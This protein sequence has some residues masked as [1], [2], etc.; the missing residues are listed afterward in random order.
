MSS[1]KCHSVS[2]LV[3]I[4]ISGFLFV[5]A[6]TKGNWMKEE[7]HI[8]LKSYINVIKPMLSKMTEG[9]P[10]AN[11]IAT[12]MDPMK[13]FKQFDKQIKHLGIKDFDKMLN[14]AVYSQTWYFG[15]RKMCF[16]A[17]VKGFE[18]PIKAFIPS[19]NLCLN[20]DIFT[21]PE[22]Y[23]LPKSQVFEALEKKIGI[24]SFHGSFFCMV[25][26]L[27]VMLMAFILTLSKSTSMYVKWKNVLIGSTMACCS[28]AVITA[29]AALL[30]IHSNFKLHDEF[31]KAKQVMHMY[32]VNPMSTNIINMMVMKESVGCAFY[33]AAVGVAMLIATVF[34]NLAE[35]CSSSN[36]E[37]VDYKKMKMEERI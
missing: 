35:I 19:V 22:K 36:E 12:T 10:V 30:N 6:F 1:N 13:A 32:N 28:I 21:N 8:N 5:R 37:K 4:L 2:G 24:D 16:S 17:T 20:N 7:I 3:L 9:S 33:Y 31:I 27:I 14:K 18:N 29:S 23:S 15:L 11:S 26:T 34:V 25:V